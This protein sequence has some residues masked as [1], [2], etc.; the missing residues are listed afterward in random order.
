[1]KPSDFFT[2]PLSNEGS[3]MPLLDPATGQASGETLTVRGFDSDHFQKALTEKRRD[4]IRIL[5]LTPEEQEI[6][7]ERSEHLLYVSLVSGWSFKAKF[8]P[9]AVEELMREAPGV[10]IQIDKFASTKVNFTSP[11]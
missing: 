9:E 1:M 2:R 8:S 4:A 10:R 5:T 3:K 7:N 11:R 6:E